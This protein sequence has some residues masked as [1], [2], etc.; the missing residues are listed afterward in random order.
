[1]LRLP[2]LPATGVAALPVGEVRQLEVQ[3]QHVLHQDPHNADASFALGMIA[4]RDG[5]HLD[6]A[7]YIGRA[8]TKDAAKADY[9]YYY[10][11]AC[12]NLG[13]LDEAV[14]AFRQ[15]LRLRS[16]FVE[17][18]TALGEL[19]AGRGRLEES[20]TNFRQAL[21]LRPNDLDIR[22]RLG[23]ALCQLGQ[24]TEAAAELRGVLRERPE[25]PGAAKHLAIAAA[26]LGRSEEVIDALRQALRANPSDADI[27]NDLGIFLARVGRHEDAAVCYR[28][29]LRIRPEFA[30][31]HNNLGNALRNRGRLEEAI[32]CFREALRIRPNYPEAHN[33]LAI[34]LK[35]SGKYEEAIAC[36]QEALRLR[37][38]Y[39]EAHHNLALAL[40]ERGRLEPAVVCYQQAV[41]L[42]PDYAEAYA[43]LANALSDLGRNTEAADACRR[44]LKLR[45][46]DARLH[47]NLGIALARQD[48]LDEAIGAYR[49]ALKLRPDFPEAY[50]DMAITLSRQGKFGE[51]IACYESALKCRPDYAEARNNLG[52]ALRSVGRFQEAVEQY[53]HAIRIKPDYADAHNNLGIAFAEVARFDEAVASY[54]RCLSMRPNHVD[55]HMNR[56][57]TWLRMGELPQG[58][59]EYE[60][61][62]KKRSVSTRPLIQPQWNGVPPAG[63]RI[64]LL[65]EQ[66]LGD[67]IQFVRY[68]RILKERGAT[69]FLECPER[70]MK[71]LARTPGIDKLIP[72]GQPLPD[73]DMYAPL[74]TLPGL[75]GTTLEAIPSEVPYIE[76]DPELL[77]QW[78]GELSGISEFR[79]GINWQGNPKY[80]GDRH[81]SIPLAHFAP[82]AKVAGVRL[83]SIQKNH[84]SEQLPAFASEHHVLDL[85]KRLDES[86]GPF[87]DTAAVLKSLDLFITSD[88]SVVH[89]AGA[90]GV[91]VWMALST[92]PD[93]RWLT[94][95]DDNPWYPTMRI[96]RQDHFMEWG[97]VFERMAVELKRLVTGSRRVRSVRIEVAPGE[98]LDKITILEIKADR[99]NDPAKLRNV[100]IEL[101]ALSES[102][103]RAIAENPELTNLMRELKQV[104]AALWDVEDE[105]RACEKSYD[106]GPGFVERAR[107]VYQLNDRRATIKR[108][109]NELLG[110]E[111][112]EEKSYPRAI[113]DA[114][115]NVS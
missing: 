61:R 114:C 28:E 11:V 23:T 22:F 52:N 12:A 74:L 51:A 63:R 68:A 90:L 13:R 79:V 92:T 8:L 18:Y 47:K 64:L 58:W 80:A 76:P 83:I 1:M 100:R 42:K 75:L 14:A 115:A 53:Q 46:D 77:K 45:P 56:A 2:E 85:G 98:M 62:W 102:R 49:E 29:A 44:A 33:N 35:Y 87:M 21:N 108:V 66:G 97:P 89:L 40:A 4:H 34:A 41:R 20:V 69:V 103:D 36:Y 10:G 59:A 67:T 57:L 84:G 26:R 17:A 7:D 106:F 37:P 73:Y 94:A 82:L 16:D 3:L 99:I 19:A 113:A 5:R 91:P 48:R 72:Q 38:A 109:I 55:A 70:L 101:A 30:D 107:S 9:Q 95:R 81:R 43:N 104:N 78:Q 54:T 60:W 110:S 112:I 50:N 105:L 15:T 6:A 25:Y 88:T 39:A 93:W 96:F 32:A 27:H 71:L 65:P 86:T 24:A 31:A 111:L